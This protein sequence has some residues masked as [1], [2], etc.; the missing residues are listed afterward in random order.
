MAISFMSVSSPS[1]P[2]SAFSSASAPR[3]LRPGVGSVADQLLQARLRLAG[4]AGDD[5]SAEALVEG[6]PGGGENPLQPT[7]RLDVLGAAPGQEG[8]SQPAL[9]K[10]DRTD[11][12]V[13]PRRQVLLVASC[14]LPEP[15][16]LPDLGPVV[17]DG[18][19]RPVVGGRFG[20]V[21]AKLLGHAAH[22]SLGSSPT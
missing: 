10:L 5:L 21:H 4:Q 14:R 16:G 17:L 13:Q 2:G 12:L 22:R 18:A 3:C 11:L 8:F 9:G 7:G 20:G 19:A 1:W 6:R 15:V